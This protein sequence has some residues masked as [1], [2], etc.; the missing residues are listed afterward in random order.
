MKIYIG[1]I[2]K[3]DRL[4][5]QQKL[6]TFL[7]AASQLGP[8]LEARRNGPPR[9]FV[10]IGLRRPGASSAR[11]SGRSECGWTARQ[12]HAETEGKSAEGNASTGIHFPFPFSGFARET[13]RHRAEVN[14]FLRQQLAD[15]GHESLGRKNIC[16]AMCWRP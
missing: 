15:R 7:A 11:P 3:I 9:R 2:G 4:D 16:P 6:F 10:L 14:R 12:R 8:A 1:Q 5:P 13:E